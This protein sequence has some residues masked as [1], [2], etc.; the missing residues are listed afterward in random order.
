MHSHKTLI[1]ILAASLAIF[2]V[3]SLSNAVIRTSVVQFS[4]GI[5]TSPE[6][7]PREVPV[8]GDGG[9][10]GGSRDV[11]ADQDSEAPTTDENLPPD[12]LEP[13]VDEVQ[14]PEAEPVPSEPTDPIPPSSDIQDEPSS[15]GGSSG[16]DNQDDHV[17]EEKP[18]A[19]LNFVQKP[20][21]V[22]ESPVETLPDEEVIEKP[23]PP[24]QNLTFA[25][26][27][28]CID[29]ETQN[30]SLDKLS[31]KDVLALLAREILT[32]LQIIEK[33]LLKHLF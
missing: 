30:F 22:N 10:G 29:V 27:P 13:S 4:M 23:L 8:T 15:S 11:T 19:S 14:E 24:K 32:W 21:V 20:S 3:F 1:S 17:A 2:M 16:N 18:K 7:P 28:S 33:F 25:E 12:E 5:A 31:L 26:L 9:T 6:E